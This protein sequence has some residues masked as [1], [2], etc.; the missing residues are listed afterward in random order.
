MVIAFVGC[1]FYLLG[2]L[3]G[4]FVR[5]LIGWSRS[6]TGERDPRLES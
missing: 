2:V 3:V 1:L 4:A 5:A 6:R